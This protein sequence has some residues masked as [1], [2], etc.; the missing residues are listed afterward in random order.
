MLWVT[1]AVA[2]VLG[3]LLGPRLAWESSPLVW[4]LYATGLL[5]GLAVGRRG[6]APGPP[7]PGAVEA[8][9]LIAAWILTRVYFTVVGPTLDPETWWPLWKLLLENALTTAACVCLGCLV[10]VYLRGPRSP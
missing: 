5:A 10:A 1:S 2:F 7:R 4:V 9:V 8:A 3:G 6:A